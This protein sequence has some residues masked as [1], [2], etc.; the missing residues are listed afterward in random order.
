MEFKSPTKM[1]QQEKLQFLNKS[2]LLSTFPK[3]CKKFLITHCYQKE[4]NKKQNKKKQKQAW[5]YVYLCSEFSFKGL[6]NKASF[7]TI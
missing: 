1:N 2:K 5:P 4:K 3:Y 6:L 7:N